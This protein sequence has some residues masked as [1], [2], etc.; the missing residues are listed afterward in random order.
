M[1]PAARFPPANGCW[2]K[3]GNHP[4]QASNVFV[5]IP[6]RASVMS[7]RRPCSS[8]PN[9]VVN[10]VDPFVRVDDASQPWAGGWNPVG[11]LPPAN[12][13]T[14]SQRRVLTYDDDVCRESTP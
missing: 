11:I 4:V 12:A 1:P 7:F 14:T 5:V 3:R 6:L 2:R 10:W 9:V 8:R 13:V